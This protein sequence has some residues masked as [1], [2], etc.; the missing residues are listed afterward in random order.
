MELQMDQM[1]EIKRALQRDQ[2]QLMLRK[3]SRNKLAVIGAS[4]VLTMV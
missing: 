4:I 3:F 1:N 2:R